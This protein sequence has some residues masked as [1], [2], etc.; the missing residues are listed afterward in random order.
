MDTLNITVTM[1]DRL[2]DLL[3]AFSEIT[4]IKKGSRNNT[5]DQT[6]IQ[7]VHDLTKEMSVDRDC[8][9]ATKSGARFSKEDKAMV[10]KIHDHAVNLGAECGPDGTQNFPA[11]KSVNLEEYVNKVRSE[12]QEEFGTDQWT[13]KTP[14][15]VDVLDDSVIA[16]FGDNY[17]RVPYEDVN[18]E[19]TFEEDMTQWTMVEKEWSDVE[20]KTR[21]AAKVAKR[22]DVKP[23]QGLS[24]YGNVS[25]ADEKNKKY[26]I[27][28]EAHIRAA[29]NYINK[30]K[31][32]GKYSAGDVAKIKRRIVSAWKQKIDKAGPP[33][34]ATKNNSLQ[35]LVNDIRNSWYEWWQ[36]DDTL[37]VDYPED[38]DEP[39]QYGYVSCPT[40]LDVLDDAIVIS[41]GTKEYRVGY[42]TLGVDD[43]D[44][45]SPDKWTQVEY[46][47][48]D[49]EKASSEGTTVKSSMLMNFCGAIKMKENGHL[50]EKCIAFSTASDPDVDADYFDKATDYGFSE[51][52]KSI[53]GPI[54]VHHCLPIKTAKGVV[55][56]KKAIG[57]ATATMDDDGIAIDG[58]LYD[59]F[60]T[61]HDEYVAKIAKTVKAAIAAGKMGWST[62]TAVHLV[63]RTAVGK[64]KHIDKWPL[65]LDFTITPTPAGIKQ[66]VTVALKSIQTPEIDFDEPE[67]GTQGAVSVVPSVSTSADGATKTITE[68][69]EVDMEK[70]ELDSAVQAAVKAAMKAQ[71]DEK[72][73]Q[74]AATKA[75]ADAEAARKKE[76]EDA[77]QAGLKA[78]GVRIVRKPVNAGAVKTQ[79]NAPAVNLQTERGDDAFKAFNYFLKTGDHEALRDTE[80]MN[81]EDAD[82]LDP[83]KFKEGMKTTYN[84]VGS[85][86]YQGLE[87]VPTEVYDKITELRDPVSIA[88]VGGAQVIPIG[89]KTRN[90]PVEKNRSGKFVIEAEGS[91]Y[92]PNAVQNFDKRA[93]TAFKFTRTVAMSIEVMEDSVADLTGWWTRHVARMEALTEN[94]YFSIGVAGGASTPEGII[95]GGTAALTLAAAGT[96]TAAEVVSLFYKLPQPYRDNPSFMCNGN[97]EGII[98]ALSGN[99]FQFQPTPSGSGGG[100][101]PM[102]ADWIISPKCK[103]LVAS[104][105]ADFGSAAKVACVGNWSEYL[106]AERSAM[107][108]FRDP[109]SSASSGLVNF[110]CHFRR[111][112]MVGVTEAFQYATSKTS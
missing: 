10:E 92:D 60:E 72:A 83:E 110:H 51:A 89:A 104:D 45:D 101:Y 96:I 46:T 97:T 109:Y 93:I 16:K 40:V 67:D 30:P 17:Y 50:G 80:R 2:A 3:S 71:A 27:D 7:K 9:K 14:Y 12:F 78:A 21:L 59:S 25:F 70:Q 77:V 6:R 90:F 65:G 33:S 57:Q 41:L 91:A 36:E 35:D 43:Y 37:P 19:I 15:C 44:F 105:M 75:A 69:Q 106:I 73:A 112:G 99:W 42:T 87:L 49:V 98:R 68:N 20:A 107:S 39:N 32:A 55:R 94:Y 58:V 31:N 23:K 5:D 4:A 82:L 54:Y 56:I 66:G 13:P 29:W 85:T 48:E 64:S 62:G 108:I 52:V 95:G 88:R 26:P 28:T 102:G 100:N 74:E 8:N 111:G 53:T 84:V 61:A 38:A 22:P 103:L 76:I 11:G 24:K 63:A 34:A 81:S 1:D 18:D 47:W 86:Q 79:A